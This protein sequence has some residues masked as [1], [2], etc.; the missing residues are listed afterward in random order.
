M[1]L[2]RSPSGGEAGV[3]AVPGAKDL[4]LGRPDRMRVDNGRKGSCFSSVSILCLCLCQSTLA[5][6]SPR[7]KYWTNSQQ[8]RQLD[9]TACP[10]A[11][12]VKTDGVPS[13]T[14]L[15]PRV[16][17]LKGSQDCGKGAAGGAAHTMHVLCS[18]PKLAG[19][20]G[21]RGLAP[22]KQILSDGTHVGQSKIKECIRGPDHCAFLPGCRLTHS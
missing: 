17:G 5:G 7:V 10:T 8:V 19:M 3:T 1:G 22:P 15:E 9:V 18:A 4:E 21:P 14:P 11:W 12:V 16:Q 20:R 13:S 2:G 6:L